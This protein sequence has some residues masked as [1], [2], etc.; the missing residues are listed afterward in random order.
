[1]HGGLVVGKQ[2]DVASKIQNFKKNFFA[3]DADIDEVIF[4]ILVALVSYILQFVN[5]Y[6]HSMDI[7][8]FAKFAFN[9]FSLILTLIA[10][11]VILKSNQSFFCQ[12]QKF[13]S[14]PISIKS[15]RLEKNPN[16]E[17][18]QEGP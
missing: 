6:L 11:V 14:L 10:D 9:E 16:L 2:F 1:M 15:G 12:G 5:L 7:S 4:A 18:Y 8:P 3:G 17:S 13:S